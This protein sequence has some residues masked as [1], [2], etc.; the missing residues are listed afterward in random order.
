MIPSHAPLGAGSGAPRTAALD[1]LRSCLTLLVVA[2]HAVLAYFVYAPPLGK[3]DRSLWWAAFPV[4]DPAKAP[5]VD[6]LVLWNDSFFMA[7]LF[8][9]SGV[10]VGPSLARKGAAGFIGDRARR[11]GLPFV[12][13]AALFAPLAYFP[14]YWQRTGAMDVAGFGIAWKQLDRWPAGPAWFLWVLFGFSVLAALTSRLM[15]R[16]FAAWGRFGAW[17]GATPW[18]CFAVWTAAAVLAYVPVTWLVNPMHWAGWGPFFVQSARGL[19][20]ALYFALGV[21]LGMRGELTRGLL[22][23]DGSL[24]CRWGLWQAAAGVVFVA[25]VVVLIVA[26]I[27]GSRGESPGLWGHAASFL[28]AVSSV[29]TSLGLLAYFAR[30]HS[31]ENRF[32]ARLRPNAFGIYLVH[33]PVAVWLQFALLGVAWPGLVKAAVVT[34]AAIAI[35]WSLAEILRRLPGARAVL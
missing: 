29:A 6:A 8:L 19:F 16:A 1:G 30:R 5:G 31:V 34:V 21:A 20:Y 18:R 23:P 27:K 26:A 24:A 12:V 9:L 22:A 32:W 4:I 14:A 35:S 3:F 11:L 33:Y 17:C 25:F 13:S 7:L 28:M 10:F 15:P 2:H